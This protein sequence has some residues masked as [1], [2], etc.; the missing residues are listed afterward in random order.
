MFGSHGKK[1]NL[2]CALKL[3]KKTKK[4][5][6]QMIKLD[7]I[8]SSVLD[9]KVK[10]STTIHSWSSHVRCVEISLSIKVPA[11]P[12]VNPAAT[13]CFIYPRGHFCSVFQ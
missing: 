4:N 7:K 9:F 8:I 1:K 12:E 13:V 3:S 6:T 5:R 11:A 2:I 10:V